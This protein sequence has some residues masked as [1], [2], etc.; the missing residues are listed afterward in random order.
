VTVKSFA[1]SFA[2]RVAPATMRSLEELATLR[3][4]GESVP[5]LVARVERLEARVAELGELEYA[6]DELRR[7]SLR[8]AEL[9][10]LVVT[11]VGAL[12]ALHESQPR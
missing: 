4:N 1:A 11:R 3:Q 5:G 7:D 8:I 10:D 6:I 2:R 9:T 12:P